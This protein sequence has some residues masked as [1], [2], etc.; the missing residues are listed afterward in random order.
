M[1]EFF[2]KHRPVEN[3]NRF[4]FRDSYTKSSSSPAQIQPKEDISYES[5]RSEQIQ[6]PQHSFLQIHNSYI[7]VQTEE[8]FEILD[9]HALHE[10]ILYN[11]IKQRVTS[12]SLQSQKLLLPESFKVTPEQQQ[13]LENHAEIL[14]KL[15]LE[16]VSFGPKTVAVQSFPNLL[17]SANPAEFVRDLLDLLVDK[18]GQFDAET[19]LDEVINMAA[20]RGAIKAGMKLTAA[21]IEQLLVDRQRCELSSRCAHGRPTIIKFSIADLEK[22]FKRT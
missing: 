22:Q 11:Q 12:E 1:D 10:R 2:R 15:G 9:Q 7:V 21:E 14:S 18:T 13:A 4:A 19:L 20:C 6:I 8:G 3:Q 16:V 17:A 5:I